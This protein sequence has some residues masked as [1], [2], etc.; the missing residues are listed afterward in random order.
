M[1][2]PTKDEF[3][4]IYKNKSIYQLKNLLKEA[5]LP[6]T[7][8]KGKGK[9]SK[10][11]LMEKLYHAYYHDSP[12][13]Q[14]RDK[15]R[16]LGLNTKGG[17]VFLERRLKDY[18]FIP[19]EPTKLEHLD[20]YDDW[21]EG[22]GWIKGI[23]YQYVLEVS[24][25][26]TYDRDSSGCTC[27][28]YCRCS[29]LTNIRIDEYSYPN[30]SYLIVKDAL[31]K[32]MNIDVNEEFNVYEVSDI[33]KYYI[34][35]TLSLLIR[36][37]IK[38]DSFD[39]LF[40]AYGEGGYYGEELRVDSFIREQLFQALKDGIDLPQLLYREYGNNLFDIEFIE[41]KEIDPKTID[42]PNKL[43]FQKCLDEDIYDWYHGIVAICSF[44]NNKYKV[45]DGYHR[46]ASAIKRGDTSVKIIV[47]EFTA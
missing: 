44:N 32:L 14:M 23:I 7:N 43:H 36:D 18:G 26:Y 45:K 39:H 33:G 38:K 20:T 10:K 27:D 15:C 35:R 13:L 30:W 37:A 8:D 17:I 29:I 31:S 40:H 42:I 3:N 25:E 9:P 34:F 19:D 16:S 11:E 22:G 24:P 2:I 46:L 41:V 6:Q 21:K 1:N 12:W 47:A 4:E 5:G 28:D